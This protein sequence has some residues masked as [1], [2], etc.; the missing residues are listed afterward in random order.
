MN[1]IWKKGQTILFQGDSITDT[2]HS[3]L[4]EENLG[5]GFVSRIHQ[6]YEAL[7][8]HI[9]IT[10]YN[11]GISGNT[12]ALLLERYEKDFKSLQPD[13]ISILIG[14]NDTWRRYS[15]DTET[16]CEQYIQNYTT[17]LENIKRDLPNTKILM[18]EPFLLPSDPGKLKF[19]EDLDPKIVAVRK[20]AGKYADYYL[21]LDGILA[22][23]AATQY[24]PVEL[25][26]DGIHPSDLGHSVIAHEIMKLLGLL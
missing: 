25:A 14:I 8:P 2:Y 22:Q 13:F 17:I 1:T 3:D 20:L 6:V 12:S 21:P 19:R 11:R 16:T 9:P 5:Q 23:Y 26:E 10:M 4:E 24:T 7:Y 15:A 18:I